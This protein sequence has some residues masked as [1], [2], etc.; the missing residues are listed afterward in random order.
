M[1]ASRCLPVVF[2]SSQLENLRAL[3][4]QQ[5][6]VV[7]LLERQADD[8]ESTR[9]DIYAEA[10]AKHDA[11]QRELAEHIADILL[12]ARAVIPCAQLRAHTLFASF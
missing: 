5:V 8:V 12:Q 6:S 4:Q 11:L 1:H 2:L 3:R 7:H 10:R 9:Q